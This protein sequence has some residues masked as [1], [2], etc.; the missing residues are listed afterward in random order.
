[1]KDVETLNISR[2]T[3]KAINSVFS[4]IGYDLPDDVDNEEAV[5][6]CLDADRLKTYGFSEAQDEVKKAI[7]EFGYVP[8]LEA[9]SEKVVLV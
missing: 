2:D 9:I 7:A 6:C 8:V 4:S 5:E 3:L 1:M